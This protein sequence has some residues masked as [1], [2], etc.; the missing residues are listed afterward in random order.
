MDNIL[1]YDISRCRFC[2]ENAGNRMRRLL[3]RLYFQIFMDNIK[4]VHLLAFVL[5]KPFYLHIKNRVRIKVNSLMLLN[6]TR[7]L[8]LISLFNLIKL[9]KKYFI[10]L[11]KKKLFKLGRVFSVSG[12]DGFFASSL[13]QDKSQRRKV[14]PFVLLL[15]LSG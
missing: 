9:I 4:S 12:T 2:T 8:Y 14:I 11:M 3:A 7:K 1:S 15:N 10:I 5:M 6:I 13:L